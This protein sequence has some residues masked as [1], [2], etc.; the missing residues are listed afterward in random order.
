MEA[1]PRPLE[2]ELQV[3]FILLLLP[4]RAPS[5]QTGHSKH[6]DKPVMMLSHF[7][8]LLRLQLN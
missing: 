8:T 5:K 7:C 3:L 2:S 1:L 4:Q 6:Q